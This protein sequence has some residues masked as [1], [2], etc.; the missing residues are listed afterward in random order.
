[1]HEAVYRSDQAGK[2][3]FVNPALVHLTGFSAEELLGA[4]AHL[5]LHPRWADG[6]PLPVRSWCNAR[7]A[8]G[9]WKSVRGPSTREWQS[10]PAPPGY[11]GSPL[12]YDPTRSLKALPKA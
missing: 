8:R 12:R 1:M 7:S 9:T 3:T 5:L 11:Q 2:I 6:A 10:G 4:D